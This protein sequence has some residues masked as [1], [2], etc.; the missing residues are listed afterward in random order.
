[1]KIKENKMVCDQ[2]DAVELKNHK[3]HTVNIQSKSKD[4]D[5][6]SDLDDEDFES[7]GHL[8]FANHREYRSAMA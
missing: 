1:M 7:V 4:Q 6:I 8:L 3:C 2:C 5:W